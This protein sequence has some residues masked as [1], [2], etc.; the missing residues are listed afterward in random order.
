[1]WL[2]VTRRQQRRVIASSGDFVPLNTPETLVARQFADSPAVA[3][4]LD[5][6]AIIQLR[7]DILTPN[8]VILKAHAVDKNDAIRQA[9]E[10]LVAAGCVAPPYI[11]GMVARERTLSTYLGNGIAIPHG[12]RADLPWVRCA[13]VAV[14]Q[15]P[16]GVEWEPGEKAYLIVGLAATGTLNSHTIILFNLLEVLQDPPTI[17]HLIHTTDPMV[18]VERLTRSASE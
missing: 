13:G 14:L 8:T 7:M 3:R 12:Q 10:V 9:G 2:A 5:A 15:L 18:I 4:L 1:M 6:L 17:E 16:A 11:D